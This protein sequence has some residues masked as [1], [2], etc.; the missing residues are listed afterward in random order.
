MERIG[1]DDSDG[2]MATNV[3]EFEINLSTIGNYIGY[4]IQTRS[5]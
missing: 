5:Q 2:L 3:N 1:R 4:Y